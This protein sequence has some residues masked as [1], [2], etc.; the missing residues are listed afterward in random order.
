MFV[1]QATRHHRLVR[2]A[3]RAP[4]AVRDARRAQ[5]RRERLRVPPRG[6]LGVEVVDGFVAL[7]PRRVRGRVRR[8]VPVERARRRHRRPPNGIREIREHVR[9]V[10]APGGV[11]QARGSAHILGEHA[12]GQ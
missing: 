12:F 11:R 7:G 8:A 5:Q 6:V 4:R 9:G 2:G 1:G 10:L 3:Q